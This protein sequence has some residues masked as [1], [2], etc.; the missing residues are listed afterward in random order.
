MLLIRRSVSDSYS[1]SDPVFMIKSDSAR[2][3]SSN[4]SFGSANS[5]LDSKINMR[6]LRFAS[7]DLENNGTSQEFAELANRNAEL[8][9]LVHDLKKMLDISRHREKKILLAL[10]ANGGKVNLDFDRDDLL[11]EGKFED[12]SFV[13]N[14]IDR[15]SWLIGLLVFQSF[16]SFILAYNEKMLQTHPAIIYFLTMLVGAGG[17][18]GNQATVRVIRELALGRLPDGS[19]LKFV[20]REVCMGFAL[21]IIVGIFGYV[22]VYLNGG[23]TV[24]ETV[25]VTIALMMIVFI[26]IVV[27]A[28]LPILFQVMN[29]DPAN[30]STTIQVI[31]DISGVFCSC[32]NI[33][34]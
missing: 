22:R 21:S 26:S 5:L 1:T 34:H 23:V 12:P 4:Y 32:A 17:N 19:K 6:L 30:S 3:L 33:G 10:D 14:M 24:M 16:S 9:M 20:L 8:E 2:S 29:L 25:T 31:M 13:N 15:G 18:A 11:D 27:G 7:N 28:L